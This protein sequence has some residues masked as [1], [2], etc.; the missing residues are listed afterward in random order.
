MDSNVVRG[1]GLVVLGGRSSN[2]LKQGWKDVGGV[3][4]ISSMGSNSDVEKVPGG[5]GV[6]GG[7]LMGVDGDVL[8]ILKIKVW[9]RFRGDGDEKSN[10]GRRTSQSRQHVDTSLIHIE[11]HK[12]PTT[13]LFDVDIGR[14]SIH[15][16]E[17]QRVSL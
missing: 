5:K 17:Y 15:H 11:S 9:L 4:K 8:G 13:V 6:I 1:D 10:Q 16:Y 12:S 7:D 2:E 3:E 14:I